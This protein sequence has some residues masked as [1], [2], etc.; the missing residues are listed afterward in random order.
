LFSV[1]HFGLHV[2]DGLDDGDA[3]ADGVGEVDGDA[4]ALDEDPEPDPL[5]PQK[6]AV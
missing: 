5:R 1:K 4:V 6:S 2:E 3:D